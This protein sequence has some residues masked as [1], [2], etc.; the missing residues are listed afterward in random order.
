[1]L[2]YTERDFVLT[3]AKVA[4]YA[5]SMCSFL[6]QVSGPQPQSRHQEADLT[7]RTVPHTSELQGRNYRVFTS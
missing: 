5:Q 2:S 7:L 4:G 1:M 3:S 6:C